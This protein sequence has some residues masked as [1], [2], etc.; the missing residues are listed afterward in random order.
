MAGIIA[1][2]FSGKDIRRLVGY[3][4]TMENTTKV[5]MLQRVFTGLGEAGVQQVLYM[6]DPA[7]LVASAFESLRAQDRG[8][9]VLRPVLEV[10]RGEPSETSLATAQMV[11]LGA[12]AIVTLGGDGTNRLVA[13]ESGD[14]PLMPISTGTNNAF[15][16]VLEPT[17]AGLAAG[18]AAVRMDGA[19]C[20]REKVL[21]VAVGDWTDLAL[22]DVAL[23][24]GAFTGTGAVWQPEAIRA[25]VVTQGEP[26]AIG[27]SAIAARICPVGRQEPFGARVRLDGAGPGP[28]YRVPL[29]PGFF[30]TVRVAEWGRVALGD[31][32]ELGSGPGVISLDGERLCV[33]PAGSRVL[34]HVSDQGPVVLVPELLLS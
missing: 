17:I 26:Q 4:T 23:L 6:P 25:L 1:N 12:A 29:G 10:V 13:K 21:R 15:P 11:S 22:V 33:V 31:G 18:L 28:A 3:G 19:G 32:V 27:L 30:G 24:D 9:M 34:V 7:R 14:V 2:P 8:S 16:F 5:R 20:R